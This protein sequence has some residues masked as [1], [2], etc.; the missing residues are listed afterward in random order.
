MK[1]IL[2]L[3]LILF[4]FTWIGCTNEKE[5]TYTLYNETKDASI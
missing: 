3:F 2:I 1:K 4:S 5:E